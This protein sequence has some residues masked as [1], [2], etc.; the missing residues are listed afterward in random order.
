[1]FNI[2]RKFPKFVVDHFAFLLVASK[3]DKFWLFPS[4]PHSHKSN[5][6]CHLYQ[7]SLTNDQ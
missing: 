7:G 6:T 4:G 3:L 5:V 2:T 1:M